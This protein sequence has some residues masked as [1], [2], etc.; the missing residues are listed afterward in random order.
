MHKPHY[1]Y[2]YM[3]AL[4]L[5]DHAFSLPRTITS[6][7]DLNSLSLSNLSHFFLCDSCEFLLRIQCGPGHDLKI[8]PCFQH[9]DL[10]CHQHSHFLTT[11]P[12]H[13]ISMDQ[14]TM[15]SRSV[16]HQKTHTFHINLEEDS[17]DFMQ[18][19]TV[20]TTSKGHIKYTP[21]SIVIGPM[22]WMA[23]NWVLNLE[24]DNVE[25]RLEV[26][27][28]IANQADNEHNQNNIPQTPMT[29]IQVKKIQVKQKKHWVHMHQCFQY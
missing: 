4:L 7:R 1:P 24:A 23:S 8:S 2:M 25:F 29:T 9:V 17:G 14:Q 12:L 27:D 13:R 18:M 16:K 11:H 19:C 5:S 20:V 21:R 22:D 10:G 28:D 15:S 26:V 3:L 6:A